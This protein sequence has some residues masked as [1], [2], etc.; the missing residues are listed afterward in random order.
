MHFDLT[1][2]AGRLEALLDMPAGV[3]R[4]AAVVC[5]PHPE[6]GGSMRHRVVHEAVRAL[7]AVGTAVLRFNFRGVGVSAGAFTADRTAWEDFDAAAD[8]LRGR[9]LG[10][11]LWAVGYSFG[12]WVALSAGARNTNVSALVG[13]APPLEGYD[14][15]G[16]PSA[17]AAKFVIAAERDERCPFGAL[18]RF[19]SSLVEPRELVVIEG[20]DHAFDGKAGEVGDAIEDLLGD[21]GDRLM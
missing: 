11:P 12:A 14:F 16:V 1:G 2:P 4:A 6:R 19:Y 10:V 15:S 7:R 18:H 8:A 13:I 9:V 21:F 5:H 17:A 3:P 20:A